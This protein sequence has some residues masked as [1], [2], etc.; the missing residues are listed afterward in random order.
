MMKC[1]S[2]VSSNSCIMQFLPL[3][4]VFNNFIAL[5]FVLVPDRLLLL[6]HFQY[7]HSD[8]PATAIKLLL[9]NTCVYFSNNHHI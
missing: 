2:S 9:V 8:H 4:S 3:V 5:Y 1:V 6:F 7:R